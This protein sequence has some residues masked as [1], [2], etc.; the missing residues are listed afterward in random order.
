MRSVGLKLS[1]SFPGGV[2]DLKSKL[3][4]IWL[5]I[6]NSSSNCSEQIKLRTS[7]FGLAVTALGLDVNEYCHF[8]ELSTVAHPMSLKVFKL[9]LL[10]ESREGLVCVTT[11]I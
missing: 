5:D 4:S 9:K 6:L 3:I 8:A 7:F 2:S 10:N 11:H 1:G